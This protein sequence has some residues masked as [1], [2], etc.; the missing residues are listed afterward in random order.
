MEKTQGEQTTKWH[1][2]IFFIIKQRLVTILTTVVNSLNF[3]QGGIV[4]LQIV[5]D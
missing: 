1:D 3:Y 4:I 2:L 5:P